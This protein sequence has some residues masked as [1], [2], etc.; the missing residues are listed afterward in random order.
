VNTRIQL[1]AL[2]LQMHAKCIASLKCELDDLQSATHGRL[3]IEQ[4]DDL[5]DTIDAAEAS[6]YGHE[7]A[8]SA[9]I[10]ELAEMVGAA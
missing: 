4:H 3:T 5:L 9:L 2:S 1:I 10:A 7:C 8:M 6:I